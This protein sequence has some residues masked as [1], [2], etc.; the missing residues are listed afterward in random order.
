MRIFN[1]ASFLQRCSRASDLGCRFECNTLQVFLHLARASLNMRTSRRPFASP[2]STSLLGVSRCRN[3]QKFHI[4]SNNA[5][6][7]ASLF[8]SI[9]LS[10][11]VCVLLVNCTPPPADHIVTIFDGICRFC[12]CV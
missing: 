8:H 10:V 6:G 11:C 5:V 2:F 3:R 4:N 7:V 1:F 12:V 9:F